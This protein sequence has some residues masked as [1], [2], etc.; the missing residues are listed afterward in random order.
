V[1]PVAYV[2]TVATHTV[3]VRV[4]DESPLYNEGRCVLS[5]ASKKTA[6]LFRHG[7]RL[8]AVR[9]ATVHT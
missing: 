2:C 8:L 7:L 4:L 1:G 5:E 9:V 6:S 3:V